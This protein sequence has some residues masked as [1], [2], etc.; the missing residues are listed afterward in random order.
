MKQSLDLLVADVKSVAHE[1]V[2]EGI[3]D[4]RV[5]PIKAMHKTLRLWRELVPYHIQS[6]L[7]KEVGGAGRRVPSRAY[8]LHVVKG[9]RLE[10][11]LAHGYAG[12]RGRDLPLDGP[13]IIPWWLAHRRPIP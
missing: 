12:S 2:T 6:E 7:H 4:R 3:R 10:A 1:P 13:G 9:E 11:L 5:S 8:W